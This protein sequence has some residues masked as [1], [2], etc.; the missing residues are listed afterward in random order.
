M[1]KS[2]IV[3]SGGKHSNFIDSKPNEA[4]SQNEAIFVNGKTEKSIVER[5][6]LQLLLAVIVFFVSGWAY[7][8]KTI[9]D[10]TGSEVLKIQMNYILVHYVLTLVLILCLYITYLKGLYIIKKSAYDESKDKYFN[11]FM[12]SWLFI[13]IVCVIIIATATFCPWIVS[14]TLVLALFVRQ[15][16]LSKFSSVQAISIAIWTIIGFPLFIS[17]M[18]LIDKKIEVIFDNEYYEI[19]D[20]LIISIDSKG[21]ACN[22]KLVCLSEDCLFQN[23]RYDV[24]ND[25]IKLQAT[26]LKG[27]N[28]K[29]VVTVGTVTPASGLN[30]FFYPYQKMLNRPINYLDYGKPANKKFVYY[31]TKK[32]NIKS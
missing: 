23:S 24:K 1:K 31:S 3:S 4:I 29:K 16:K 28:N 8:N 11:L 15:L 6:D 10:F 27:N 20:N 32:V 19:D 9:C 5:L 2:N 14:A 13:L 22:Q 18:T 12:D 25:M 7:L 21:Y 26:S 30:F 17:T